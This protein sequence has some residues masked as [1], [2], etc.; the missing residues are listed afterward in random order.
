MWRMTAFMPTSEGYLMIAGDDFT[1]TGDRI[2]SEKVKIGLSIVRVLDLVQQT[3]V[4]ADQSGT[5]SFADENVEQGRALI[6][7]RVK[8]KV[9]D[10]LIMAEDRY[11]IKGVRPV[12][13]MYGEVD[14]YQAELATWV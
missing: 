8:P 13:D 9:N 7:P 10:I 2:Y 4:R 1:V 3:S 6:H 11:E 5:K 12:Y 14:H